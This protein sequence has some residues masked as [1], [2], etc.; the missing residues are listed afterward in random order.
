[1]NAKTKFDLL[2]CL[3][4]LAPFVSVLLVTPIGAVMLLY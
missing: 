2:A 4:V 3:F 1:M